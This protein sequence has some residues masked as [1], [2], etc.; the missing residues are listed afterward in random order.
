M[1]RTKIFYWIFTILFGGLMIFTSIPDLLQSKEAVDFIS[2]LGY[3]NYFIPFIGVAKLLGSIAILTPGYPRLKEWA[4]AGLAYD[5]IAAVYSQIAVAGIQ[6]EM[7]FM[8][9]P[10]VLGVLSYFYYH[11]LQKSKTL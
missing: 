9:L 1:K 6:P 4:Y 7:S 10:I 3:P 8:I 5:L 2:K 11:R